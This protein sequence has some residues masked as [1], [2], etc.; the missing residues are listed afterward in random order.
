LLEDFPD[1]KVNACTENIF[2][3][4]NDTRADRLTQLVFCDIS[5]PNK[6]GRFNVY[7]DIKAKLINRGVPEYEIA[8]IHDAGNETR[9][10]ELFAKVRSGKVRV[11]F[12]S[13][14]KMGAGTNVQDRLIALHDLDC[15]WRPADLEQR[16]GR[17]IRQG[18]KNPK[19]M[20]F[21]ISIFGSYQAKSF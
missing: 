14:F 15:P 6:D 3:I 10:K 4:W 19:V 13:T 1:S 17:I 8:F 11:L 18:N 2:N 20:P 16:S 12:G 21:P 7:D 5:T 9:K